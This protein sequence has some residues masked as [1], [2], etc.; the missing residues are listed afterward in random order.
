[1]KMKEGHILYDSRLNKTVD[2][3]EESGFKEIEYNDLKLSIIIKKGQII[4]IATQ[5][6]FDPAVEILRR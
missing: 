6:A 5:P 2:K 1:M 3:G 4:F